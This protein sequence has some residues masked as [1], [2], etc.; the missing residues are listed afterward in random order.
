MMISGANKE[1][2][3]VSEQRLE[4]ILDDKRLSRPCQRLS[5]QAMATLFECWFL[6]EER[7][8][9]AQAGQAVFDEIDRIE[10]ALSYFVPGSD[11]SRFNRLEKGNLKVGI[12]LMDC[13]AVAKAIHR[14]TN[15]AF[16][17]TI[18]AK[19]SGRKPWD[20]EGVCESPLKGDTHEKSGAY[21]LKHIQANP[22]DFTLIK[23]LPGVE[24][25]L[26]GLAKGYALD[27]AVAV[28]ADWGMEKVLLHSGQSTMVAL[29]L[30][31]PNQGWPMRLLDPGNELD[32]LGRFRLNN[33]AVSCSAQTHEAHI[34]DPATGKP[35]DRYACVWVIAPTAIVADAL[36]TAFMAMPFDQVETYCKE[37]PEVSVLLVTVL[38]DRA[39]LKE[40]GDWSQYHLEKNV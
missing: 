21:G 32:V 39:F 26:G 27:Q 29:G 9:A 5:H 34:L 33:R 8:E 4:G 13:I 15:G 12:E 28:L 36:S 25:D 1:L 6:D 7:C 22:D 3:P 40:I 30:P 10:Q 11:V 19:L 2:E 24:L 37:Y 14:Q 35:V 31:D 20:Q 18:G 23:S 16:D 38:D 17:P